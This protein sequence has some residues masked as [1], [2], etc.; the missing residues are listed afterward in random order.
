[1]HQYFRRLL[2]VFTLILSINSTAQL[3]WTEVFDIP[4]KGVWASENGEI[5]TDF[6][7]IDWS[8][9]Y[10]GCEFSNQN[11]YAKTVTTAGGRFE[12]LDSDGE[13]VWTTPLIDIAP[14]DAVNISLAASETGSNAGADRKYLKAFYK[15]NGGEETPFD[16]IGVAEGDWG[17]ITLS[18]QRIAGETLQLV[19]KMNSSY[20]ND[21]V[22]MDNIM[23]EAIDS[24][25]FIASQVKIMNSPLFAFSEDETAISA[26]TLNSKGDQ[27]IDSSI[28]LR[29]ISNDIN[30][31]ALTYQN[32]V[33]TWQVSSNKNG[34]LDYSIADLDGILS[35]DSKRIQ[36]F[37]R[38]DARL[39]ELFEQDILQ[40]WQNISDWELSADRPIS[41]QQSIKHALKS[42]AGT[43]VLTHYGTTFKLSEAEYLFSFKL[44][45]GNWDPSNTNLFYVWLKNGDGQGYA[46]GVNAS[47]STDLVS[48]WKMLDG[49]PAQLLAETSLEWN[50]NMTV[51]LDLMRSAQGEW[52][53]NA[54]NLANGQS[55]SAGVFDTEFLDVDLL[56]L[57]YTFTST[58]AGELWFDDLI[59]IGQNASPFIAA[60]K[61]TDAGRFLITFNEAIRME[62]LSLSDLKLASTAGENVPITSFDRVN[63]QSI[64]LHTDPVAFPFLIVSAQSLIDM[65]GKKTA[66]SSFTF[67]NS[68]PAREHDVVINEI[69][70]D[71]N[72]PLGLPE[73]EY[74]ELYNRSNHYI[75][76]ENWTLFVRNTNFKLP[77]KLLAPSEYLILC[78][79]AFEPQFQA[80]G[81]VLPLDKFPALLNAGVTLKVLDASQQLIDS[82]T[83][84]DTWYGDRLKANGGFSLERI[85]LDRFCGQ[86]GNWIASENTKGGTPGSVNSV[87]RA[88]PDVLPP[89]LTA[90]DIVS[91]EQIRLIFSEALQH[92]LAQM[93]NNY[94][95]PGLSI[96]AVEYQAGN[97][98]VDLFLRNPMQHNRE[99]QVIVKNMAD[100][101]GNA[102][103]DLTLPF[104]LVTLSA[105][106]VLISEVLFNPFTNG[107]DFVELYNNSGLNID[108]ADLK[109]ATRNDSLQLKSIYPVSTKHLPFPAGT[110]RAFSKDTQNI[111]AFYPVPYP[112]HLMQMSSFPAYNNDEGRVVLLDDSLQ[113]IDEFL[114]NE[115]MHSKWLSSRDGVS[116]ERLSF[117]KSTND[118][119]YW[120]SA[121]SLTGYATPGYENSQTDIP[122]GQRIA[123]ELE[124]DVVSPNGDAYNDE[125]VITFVLDQTGYIAN[126]YVFDA[127]GREVRRLSNNDLIGNQL[128]VTYDLRKADGSLL[129]MGMYVIFTELVHLDVKKQLFKNAFLVTDR[130]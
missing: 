116:L 88:N 121:S 27:I 99:Y 34:W 39:V 101:C 22:I 112:D 58:R 92:S 70:A 62:S 50:E 127:S 125:L 71:P 76:L 38:A 57:V 5:I 53:L 75:Q 107:Y 95:I 115:S 19:V 68:L 60:A 94:T 69:M 40:G 81:Q 21:K 59:V 63:E 54:T 110:Y 44:K 89:V 109:L 93:L 12:V 113:V 126:L 83:Y 73:A 30:A 97:N 41:G 16:P 130:N 118:P 114:Y 122:D 32:G 72:P 26:I 28:Q 24:A 13:V 117:E 31:G 102:I 80:Y 18:Q 65:E 85:D 123:I 49:S 77:R 29:F 119:A 10:E 86:N 15:L 1:M 47:G 9:T 33:Y 108:L 84:S 14:Y 74:I 56:E 25:S 79:D 66:T 7:E 20:A 52:L 3:V 120:Q 35:P 124:S 55:A 100:E 61:A 36:F 106:Q 45:N 87:N 8:L 129:P 4:D 82:V 11:D 48:M 2:T 128:S 105:G 23:V 104:T 42:I 17:A 103:Q 96:I 43:S 111:K 91:Y 90:I 6:S 51:Q 46:I 78:D 67:E 64:L 98:M 37:T